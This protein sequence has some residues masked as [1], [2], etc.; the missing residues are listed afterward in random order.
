MAKVQNSPTTNTDFLDKI[1]DSPAVR[2]FQDSLAQFSR[3]FSATVDLFKNFTTGLAQVIQGVGSATA[4]AV[5]PVAAAAGGA[6]EG[7]AAAG[8][9]AGL[10]A[11]AGPAA[12]VAI[13]FEGL[14][15]IVQSAV[16]ESRKWVEA[17]S[18]ATLFQF[19]Y[20]VRQLNATLGVAFVPL[21]DVLGKVANE[22]AGI[23]YPAMEALSPVVAAVAEIFGELMV[24]IGGQ[25]SSAIQ[26]L[27]PSFKFLAD[28]ISQVA[29]VFEVIATLVGGGLLATLV[30]F[31]E[32]MRPI[33]EI[34]EELRPAIDALV[35]AL[36]AGIT[37]MIKTFSDILRNF[38]GGAGDMEAF[39]ATLHRVVE[40]LAT[41]AALLLKFVGLGELVGRIREALAGPRSPA[42]IAVQD[43]RISGFEEISKNL[44]IAS[45]QAGGGQQRAVEDY[46]ADILRGID[47]V[48][49]RDL[50]SELQRIIVNAL[51]EVAG[52]N[53]RNVPGAV[54]G[55]INAFQDARA[56]FLRGLNPLG[57]F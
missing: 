8:A 20:A 21:F 55:G 25:F 32:A 15:D 19:D 47:S 5:E 57:G 38:F 53:P 35:R 10:A 45:V 12:L 49:N 46:L 33:M 42:P 40:G 13:A 29:Q 54:A 6:T 4:S 43:V 2:A 18:P 52:L 50:A 36:N 51:R 22:I 16:S 3:T 31:Q 44:A 48:Q 56:G 7:V 37:V 39:R 11:I 30:L 27:I 28:I 23:L 17:L 24:T 34:F 41:F 9:D 1:F 26:L 14:I